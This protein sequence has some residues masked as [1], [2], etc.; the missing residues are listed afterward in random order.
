MKFL[1]IDYG[2]KR[3]GL[4]LSDDGGGFAFPK[5]II[6]NDEGVMEK[7]AKILQNEGVMGIVIGESLDFEGGDN[8]IMAE[9]KEF[10]EKLEERF[11]MKVH[12]EKEFFTTVEARRYGEEGEKADARAAALIL[13]RFLDRRSRQ[14][15]GS[16]E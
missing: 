7:I 12:K 14:R 4:A 3:I 11:K 6:E 8:K 9:I 16:Q 10:I 2:K 13:Q 1:G 15:E 5:E